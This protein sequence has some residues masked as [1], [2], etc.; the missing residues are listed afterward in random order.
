MPLQSF[1]TEAHDEKRK[2]IIIPAKKT[3]NHF[4][5]PVELRGK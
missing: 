5:I 1:F 4:F 3:N 2:A